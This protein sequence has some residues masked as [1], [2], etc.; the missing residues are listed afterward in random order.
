MDALSLRT[1]L[2]LDA[3]IGALCGLVLS[4]GA[5]PLGAALDLPP[6]LLFWAGLLLFPCAGLMLLA[7]GRR[8]PSR[9][10]ARLVVV[11]NWAWAAASL[12]VLALT[13]PNAAGAA[14]VLAQAAVVAGFAW[15]EGRALARAPLAA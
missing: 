6:G 12:G 13:S 11:G 14:L 10:L 4:L 15:T 3:L 1:L 9:P 7:A 8:A 2:R 5:G